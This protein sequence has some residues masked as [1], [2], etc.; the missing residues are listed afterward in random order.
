MLFTSG[1]FSSPGPM[2][3]YS[4]CQSLLSPILLANNFPSAII[5]NGT[6][7]HFFTIL[8]ATSVKSSSG[9]WLSSW[10]NTVLKNSILRV[11]WRK[12]L[13]FTWSPNLISNIKVASGYDYSASEIVIGQSVLDLLP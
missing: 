2:D 4:L 12:G 13:Q 3:V 1:V 7:L 5:A 9:V 11:L 6:P 10:R 8:S